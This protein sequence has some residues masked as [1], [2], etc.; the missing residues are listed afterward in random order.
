MRLSSILFLI[1]FI[2]GGCARYQP[3]SDFPDHFKTRATT[4]TIGNVTVSAVVLS[5]EEERQVFATQLSSNEIQVLW[6]EISNRDKH[7]YTLLMPSIDR[8]YFSP[9]EAAWKSK[10]FGER[11]HNDKTLYFLERHIPVIIDPE[12][13]VSGFVFTNID[14]GVKVITVELI[15]EQDVPSFQFVLEVPGFEADFFQSR[16]AERYNP[17]DIPNLDLDGL[18]TYL[19]QLPCCALG[20]DRVTAGDPINLVV[21]GEGEA[22]LSA[23]VRQGWD[24]TEPAILATAWRTFWSSLFGSRYRTS[25]VSA[26][27]LFERP[28]DA[29]LQK[30]RKSVDERNH[31][32]LWRAPVSY[33]SAPV[34]VGQISRDIGVRLSSKTVVTHKIDPIIDEAR[35]YVLMDL[36]A[37]RSVQHYGLVKGVGAAPLAAPRFNFTNDPYVTDGL[38]AVLILNEDQVPFE[39]TKFLPWEQ[40]QK[41]TKTWAAAADESALQE[42]QAPP[43]SEAE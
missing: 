40:L 41:A 26:L 38:R 14:P 22:V 23:F 24:L 37:S 16:P 42:I 19:E 11:G 18:R 27:Y 36:L 15:Y 25:P 3:P 12:S 21:V 7:D 10:G 39:E 31:L 20:G 43:Q 1:L 34:W 28:Q 5:V 8:D 13:T 6:L 30:S 2:S 35:L 9:G 32:R 17:A 29:A 33:Q 4:R